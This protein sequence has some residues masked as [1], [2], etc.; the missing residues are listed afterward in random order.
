MTRKILCVAAHPD[1]EALGLGGTLIRHAEEGD[2]VYIIILSEGEDA[3]SSRGTRDPDR[4]GRADEWCQLSGT[5][6]YRIYD[7]PDQKFDTISRLEIVQ[8][9]E[10]DIAE[11]RP[12]IIYLH[13]PNDINTDHQIAGQAVLTAVRPMSTGDMNPTLFAFETPSTTDQAPQI[14][15]FIFYP[16]HY[17]D[18]QSVW[19]KKMKSLQAYKNEMGAAPHPR[20]PESIEA[21]AIKRGAESG[22]LKAEAFALMRQVIM[23]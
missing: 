7:L 21:L 18:V 6:L 10:K 16:N 8:M 13:H 23:K 19:T 14:P 1:D 15:S 5:K 22:L 3:K 12:D 11:I 20:S 9:L 17:V 2:E 4:V